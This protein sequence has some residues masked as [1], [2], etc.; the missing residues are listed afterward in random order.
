MGMT[1]TSSGQ[2]LPLTRT[3]SFFVHRGTY[4]PVTKKPIRTE[5]NYDEIDVNTLIGKPIIS[6]F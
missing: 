2:I 5:A 4:D 6:Y 1:F 3:P